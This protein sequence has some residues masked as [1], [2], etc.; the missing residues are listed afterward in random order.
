MS[1]FEGTM[2]PGGELVEVTTELALAEKQKLHKALRRFDM[3]FFTLCAFV[4]LDTIGAVAAGGAEGFFWLTAMAILFVFPYALVMSEIGSTFTQE[5][6]PYE[7]TESRISVRISEPVAESRLPVGSSAKS[8]VGRE[9]SARAIA[10]R[11]C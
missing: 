6:G 11:C 2:G 7:S 1:T 10:T 8:T 5:G 4:G 9:T 3:V